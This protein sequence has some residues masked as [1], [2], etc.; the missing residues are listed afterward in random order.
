MLL[1]HK[2]RLIFLHVRKA[3]GSS[4]KASL[5]RDLGPGDIG[6]GGWRDA[7]RV[8]VQPNRW[9]RGTAAPDTVLRNLFAIPRGHLESSAAVNAAT[10]QFAARTFGFHADGHVTAPEVR[11]V[12]PT[13]WEQYSRIAV[14]RDPFD[15]TVSD[16]HWRTRGLK[17]PP[18]LEEY[19]SAA[20]RG[21]TLNSIVPRIHDAWSFV[22]IDDEVSVAHLCRFEHLS[23]DL[24]QALV[25]SG[26]SWDAWLPRVKW[27]GR[28]GGYREYLTARTKSL[29]QLLYER[30]F[31]AFGYSSE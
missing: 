3:A 19:L 14:V 1:S 2:H 22:S 13:E 18:S 23:A 6:I 17:Q 31:D 27:S 9:A 30:E 21:A 16:Y 15:R 20:R 5:Y 26:Y 29:I 12:F 8:G 10:K 25:S 28:E 24:Q 7:G 11:R 4:I